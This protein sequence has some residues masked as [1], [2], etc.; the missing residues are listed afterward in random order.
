MEEV[1]LAWTRDFW[2]LGSY[3]IPFLLHFSD[4]MGNPTETEIHFVEEVEVG[5]IVDFKVVG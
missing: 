5:R 3:V 4:F 1:V 2:E